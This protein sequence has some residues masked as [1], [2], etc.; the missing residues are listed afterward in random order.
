MN[1]IVFQYDKSP[2]LKYIRQNTECEHFK[3]N[4]PNSYYNT[5]FTEYF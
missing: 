2:K 1:N 5:H 4:I 3:Y